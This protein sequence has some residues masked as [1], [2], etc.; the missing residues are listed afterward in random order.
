MKLQQSSVPQRTD[1]ETPPDVFD[2]YHREFGFTLDA[3]A[4]AHNAKC[5][6]YFT[7]EQDGVAQDWGRDV[8]WVNPPFGREIPQFIRKAY[9]SS[10]AGATVVLLVPAR[11]DTAWW[12]DYV[13]PYAERRFLRGRV[14]FVGAQWNAP[15]PCVIVIFRPLAAKAA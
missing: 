13:E 5:P 9:E 3:A 15:F 2:R 7:A 6:R 10:L 14:K 12:H 11:T 8:V 1:W 4:S